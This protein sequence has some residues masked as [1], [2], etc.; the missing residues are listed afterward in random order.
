MQDCK[1]DSF[2]YQYCFQFLV[3]PGAP[4]EW[5]RLGADGGSDGEAKTQVR[6]TL[7]PWP[8]PRTIGHLPESLLRSPL[9]TRVII[10]TVNDGNNK[11]NFSRTHN[12]PDTILNASHE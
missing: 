1:T 4:W 12:I 10:G 3:L 5:E 8:Q 7:G 6:H 9:I 11:E 2:E